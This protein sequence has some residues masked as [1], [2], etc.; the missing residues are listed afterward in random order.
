MQN[1]NICHREKKNSSHFFTFENCE[2]EHHS[3]DTNLTMSCPNIQIST[4]NKEVQITKNAIP[5]KYRKSNKITKASSKDFDHAYCLDKINNFITTDDCTSETINCDSIFHESVEECALM[6]E[7]TL[8]DIDYSCEP[9]AG[10]SNLSGNTKASCNLKFLTP[11]NSL[12]FN[13]ENLCDYDNKTEN[14]NDS[15]DDLNYSIKSDHTLRISQ[16][17]LLSEKMTTDLITSDTIKN[18]KKNESSLDIN[19]INLSEGNLEKIKTASGIV[20]TD[21]IEG[22]YEELHASNVEEECSDHLTIEDTSDE[23][24]YSSSSE[25]VDRDCS[26]IRSKADKINYSETIASIKLSQNYFTSYQNDDFRKVSREIMPS[27]FKFQGCVLS[28]FGGVKSYQDFVTLYSKC[29]YKSHEQRF[30]FVFMYPRDGFFR[31]FVYGSECCSI[32]HEGPQK[33][34]Q[35]RAGER[36]EAKKILKIT[37]PRTYEAKEMEIVNMEMFHEGNPQNLHPLSV[38]QKAKSEE[39]CKNDKILQSLHLQDLMQK[40]IEDN[41][42]I[43]PYIRWAGIPLTVYMFTEEQ[44]SIIEKSDDI[45]G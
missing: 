9:H 16:V 37:N 5:F 3:I 25:S 12:E 35:L 11:V 34:T 10:D 44:F 14:C 26:P 19:K 29:A 23:E 8:A 18:N 22:E 45:A 41:Y 40:C 24:E 30:K 39:N 31:V 20:Y 27:Q 7:G 42:L 43:D 33:Y 13:K 38:Y 15:Q 17:S 4:S 1:S 28:F 21:G 36:K 2:T 32:A 6:E